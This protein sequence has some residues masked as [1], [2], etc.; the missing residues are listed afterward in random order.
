MAKKILV[1]DDSPTVR[2]QVSMALTH[3]G[4]DVVEAFDGAMGVDTIAR[5]RS[6]ALVICDINM[7][8]MNGITMVSEVKKAPENSALPILMLTTENQPALM[9]QAREAGAKGWMVKPFDATQL[10]ATAKKLLS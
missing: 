1:V 8:R 9:R 2:Q 6:I 3:A 7:P 10:V 4:F 5:D